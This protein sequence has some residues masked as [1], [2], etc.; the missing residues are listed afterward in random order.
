MYLMIR[1]KMPFFSIWFNYI[2]I[3]NIHPMLIILNFI[4][5]KHIDLML[6][7]TMGFFLPQLPSNQFINIMDNNGGFIFSFLWGWHKFCQI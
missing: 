2:I 7:T 5:L 6:L 1:L 4:F 3:V